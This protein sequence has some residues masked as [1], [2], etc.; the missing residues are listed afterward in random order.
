MSPYNHAKI[1]FEKKWTVDV[2][3]WRKEQTIFYMYR[4]DMTDC[5]CCMDDSRIELLVAF[6][7]PKKIVFAHHKSYYQPEFETEFR[8]LA[9]L[10][11]E[12]LDNERI[13]L[14]I[15]GEENVT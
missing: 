3:F 7:E 10:K 9:K 14:N 4:R 8:E 15:N 1:D 13:F 12:E 2:V 11:K 5:L 6:Y